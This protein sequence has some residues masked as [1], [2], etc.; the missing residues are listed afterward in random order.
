MVR[1]KLGAL[2]AVSSLL[3]GATGGFVLWLFHKPAHDTAAELVPAEA[4]AYIHIFLR[5]STQQRLALEELL[6]RLPLDGTP[7]DEF[8]DA[9]AGIVDPL[10]RGANLTYERDVRPWLGSQMAFFALEDLSQQAFLI[11][12]KPDREWRAEDVATKLLGRRAD[13]THDMIGNYLAIGTVVALDAARRTADGGLSLASEP[14]FTATS[15][16]LTDQRVLT[17]YLPSSEATFATAGSVRGDGIVFDAVT[18]GADPPGDPFTQAVDAL[19]DAD[20][21]PFALVGGAISAIPAILDDRVV[22]ALR[23]TGALQDGAPEWDELLGDGYEA[24]AVI[25]VTKVRDLAGSL[26]LLDSFAGSG[27]GSDRLGSALDFLDHISHIVAGT[28]GA[29]VPDAPAGE[30]PTIRLLIGVK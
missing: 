24:S 19:A 6:H 21:L 17:I 8:K 29:S 4:S 22:T 11:A 10:L 26:G 28:R 25:D 18:R 13:L 16:A 23:L 3:L 12:V 9:I 30:E 20:A 1:S 7:S 5:P 15:G 2:L 14:A 27:E